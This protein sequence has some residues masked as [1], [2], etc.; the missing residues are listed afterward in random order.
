MAATGQDLMAADIPPRKGPPSQ[1]VAQDPHHDI[2][3]P[4]PTPVQ[5][6]LEGRTSTA[7]AVNYHSSPAAALQAEAVRAEQAKAAAARVA[8]SA[9]VGV[10]QI[11]RAS[12]ERRR[13][14]KECLVLTAS[15]QQQPTGRANGTGSRRRRWWLVPT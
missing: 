15:E 2:A 5:S 11:A 3:A 12:G 6:R 14:I 8:F 4:A 9:G 10:P 7:L 1:P 13:Q